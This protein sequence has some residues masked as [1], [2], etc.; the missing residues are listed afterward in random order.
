MKLLIET[1]GPLKW[2]EPPYLCGGRGALALREK[3]SNPATRFSAGNAKA[4]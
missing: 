4:S 2:W 1:L 3:A